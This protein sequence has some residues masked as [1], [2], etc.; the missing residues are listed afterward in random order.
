MV[1]GTKRRAVPKAPRR[2]RSRASY[3][4]AGRPPGLRRKLRPPA[5]AH[6]TSRAPAAEVPRRQPPTRLAREGRGRQIELPQWGTRVG[7]TLP[8]V[9]W[10]GGAG[11]GWPGCW[12]GWTDRGA[13]VRRTVAARAWDPRRHAFCLTHSSSVCRIANH[14]P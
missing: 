3:P 14:L 10:R 1:S 11:R 2:G 13:R 9:G 6:A 7:G 5:D 4:G 12:R 8:R